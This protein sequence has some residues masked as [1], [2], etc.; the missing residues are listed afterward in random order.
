MNNDKSVKLENVYYS[1]DN[2]NQNAPISLWIVN[3]NPDEKGYG[4]DDEADV[5]GTALNVTTKKEGSYQGYIN[6]R[7]PHTYNTQN[8]CIEE[9]YGEFRNIETKHLDCYKLENIISKQGKFKDTNT[10]RTIY[11]HLIVLDY[12]ESLGIDDL[13]RFEIYINQ[14]LKDKY[15]SLFGEDLKSVANGL[16]EAKNKEVK[17]L[18]N[19][20]DELSM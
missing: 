14:N 18:V 11:N 7:H 8:I 1:I 6:P 2:S 10:L 4:Y 20:D 12:K 5:F 19:N 15:E 3:V 17:I 13:A 9:E 16:K